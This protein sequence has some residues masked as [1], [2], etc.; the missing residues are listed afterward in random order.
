MAAAGPEA[1]YFI[2]DGWIGLLLQQSVKMSHAGGPLDRRWS[3]LGHL[4]DL[5][6]Y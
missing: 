3:D 4:L 2:Q 1:V 5:T 6:A